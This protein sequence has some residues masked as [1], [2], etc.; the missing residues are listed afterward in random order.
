MADE[1]L[2]I[3]TLVFKIKFR[4]YNNSCDHSLTVII[5][6]VTSVFEITEKEDNKPATSVVN[7]AVEAVREAPKES[8]LGP[9][10]EEPEVGVNVVVRW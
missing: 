1:L 2:I 6:S 9:G 10:L 7:D 4:Q 8:L 3:L 5:I